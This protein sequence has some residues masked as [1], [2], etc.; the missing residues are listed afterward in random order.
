MSVAPYSYPHPPHHPAP[1]LPLPYPTIS[2][3][4]TAAL[5]K[6]VSST[7]SHIPSNCPPVVLHSAGPAL[8]PSKVED[9]E[10]IVEEDIPSDKLLPCPQKTN[11]GVGV[12][13]AP[14][15]LDS[16]R[17]NIQRSLLSLMPGEYEADAF[18]RK[19]ET[20]LVALVGEMPMKQLG[21]PEKTAEQVR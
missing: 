16:I 10:V 7:Q 11:V 15:P 5:T 20:A 1:H 8:P 17:E 3:V 2:V 6:T 14:S 9:V 4:H 19:V 18:K 21:Y 13:A 12:P